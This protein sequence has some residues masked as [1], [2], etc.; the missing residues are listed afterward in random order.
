M[1]VLEEHDVDALIVIGGGGS[2]AG[3]YALER[4]GLAVVGVAATVDNDLYGADPSIGVDTALNV[5]LEAIDRLKA[6]ASSRQRAFIVEVMGRQCGYLALMTGIAGGAEAVVVPELES[7]PERLA[8]DLR[9]AYR[10]G[11]T[12]ALVVV[13]EG[14]RLNGQALMAYFQAHPDQ[15]DFELRLTTLGSVQRGGVPSAFDRLLATRL[16]AAAIE[17]LA[18]D[19]RGVLLGPVG[20]E[21]V[22]T[23]LDVAAVRHKPLDAHTRHLAEVLAR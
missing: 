2:Q 3:A 14:A 12:H 10:R 5:A 17:A 11:K 15:S 21:V 9:A 16:G 6:T 19:E 20:G 13:S 8:E 23:P 4:L 22:S 7:P 1:R 18:R